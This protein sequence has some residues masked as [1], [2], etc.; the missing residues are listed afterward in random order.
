MV[1]IFT[2][3]KYQLLTFEEPH[4]IEEIMLHDQMLFV[5]TSTDEKNTLNVYKLEEQAT[6]NSEDQIDKNDVNKT[7]FVAINHLKIKLKEKRDVEKTLFFDG[8]NATD[9]GYNFSAGEYVD[10]YDLI[11]LKVNWIKFDAVHN[12]YSHRIRSLHLKPVDYK[13]HLVTHMTGYLILIG[14]SIQL[15]CPHDYARRLGN[16]MITGEFSRAV[17]FKL[18]EETDDFFLFDQNQVFYV[19]LSK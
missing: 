8:F 12:A 6:R 19:K 1:D 17:S 10:E 2:R 9:L 5:L 13:L 18:I 11:D 15:F 4:F 7:M 3:E 14:Q 16:L